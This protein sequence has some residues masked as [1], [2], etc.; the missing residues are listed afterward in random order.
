MIEVCASF[1]VDHSEKLVK[2]GRFC[3]LEQ[4]SQ[5]IYSPEKV[6]FDMK[7]GAE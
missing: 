3:G 7:D 2:I 1:F 5:R 6:D 4:S